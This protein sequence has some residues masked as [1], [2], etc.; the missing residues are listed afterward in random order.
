VDFE[1]WEAAR[2]DRLCALG[3]A[4]PS[5]VLTQ[6]GEAVKDYLNKV[7]PGSPATGVFVTTE[8]DVPAP[9][10]PESL[11]AVMETLTGK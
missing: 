10:P 1:T 5:A 4:V 2:G 11:R 6:G 9:T 7:L 3:L 8:G